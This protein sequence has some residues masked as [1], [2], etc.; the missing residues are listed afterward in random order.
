MIKTTVF[1]LAFLSI[2]VMSYGMPIQ[3]FAVDAPLTVNVQFASYREGAEIEIY[4]VVRD[5]DQTQDVSLRLFD[6]NSTL[7]LDTFMMY[8]G[9]VSKIHVFLNLDVYSSSSSTINRIDNCI[10]TRDEQL[11]C[12]KDK[13]DYN[14]EQ[15]RMKLN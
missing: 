8:E 10:G 12:Y 11:K 6:P 15:I 1:L 9:S 2:T 3:S 7:D 5:Y 4:G 14:I 13:R